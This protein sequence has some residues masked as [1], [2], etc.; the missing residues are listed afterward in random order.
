[1]EFLLALYLISELGAGI[2]GVIIVGAVFFLCLMGVALVF[3]FVLSLVKSFIEE[4]SKART[5]Q[6]TD[7]VDECVER[8]KDSLQEVNPKILRFLKSL[9][10]LFIYLFLI[11]FWRDALFDFPLWIQRVL[12]ILWFICIIITFIGGIVLIIEGIKKLQ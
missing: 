7:V 8:K 9:P 4:F 11:Y 12:V 2:I 6:K 5:E 10:F 3:L 1:M